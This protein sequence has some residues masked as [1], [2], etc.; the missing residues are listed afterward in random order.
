MFYVKTWNAVRQ[1]LKQHFKVV[2]L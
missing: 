1:V 2:T